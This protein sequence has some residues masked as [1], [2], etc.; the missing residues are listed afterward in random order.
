MNEE[1]MGNTDILFSNIYPYRVFK[2]D[3]EKG[4]SDEYIKG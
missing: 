2:I 3:I 4:T 1:G